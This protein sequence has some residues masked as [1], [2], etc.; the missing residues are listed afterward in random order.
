MTMPSEEKEAIELPLF[1]EQGQDDGFS[2]EYDDDHDRDPGHR[3]RVIGMI[4]DY[5][6]RR[7]RR[8][9]RHAD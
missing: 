7:N 9:R 1:H 8:G 6:G 3:D 2:E 4:G 5:L